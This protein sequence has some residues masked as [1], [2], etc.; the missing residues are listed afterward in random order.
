MDR[1]R[2][3][4]R[5]SAPASKKFPVDDNQVGKNLDDGG[6][7]VDRIRIGT[8]GS[9]LALW[10]ANFIATELKKFFP[11]MAVE[12]IKISTKGDRILDAPLSK[13]GGKGL[14][15]REIETA[16]LDGRIDLAVHSLKDVPAELPTEFLIGAITRRADPFDAFVSNRFGA[17]EELPRGAVVGTSSLRRRAQLL[18]LRSDLTVE[19][20]RGNVETRLKK[21]D[22]GMFDAIILAAAGLRRLG[23]G[24]R[25]RAELSPTV[26]MP[27]VG[28]GALAVE[29]VKGNRAVA[30]IIRVLDD[31]LTRAAVSAERSFLRVIEGGCQVPVG[32]YATVEAKKI[33]VEGLIASLDGVK[34]IRG[35]TVGLIDDAG[36]LG[37]MLAEK[38]LSDGGRQ[39]LEAL[40]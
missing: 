22:A 11:S 13:I 23:F 16:L 3:G 10:Q 19:D 37:S 35:S 38:L 9:A 27:A 5:G 33:T 4:T 26:M 8:R 34:I 25:I 18:A 31:G 40:K 1:I 7:N 24:D 15:T 20:L 29:L 14:F 39:I 21:L 30:E 2:I 36:R 6:F 12:L 17:I 28:Q 32:V